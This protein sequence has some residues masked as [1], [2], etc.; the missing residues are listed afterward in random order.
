MH[1]N[2][3]K[4]IDTPECTSEPARLTA[5][6]VSKEERSACTTC[7]LDSAGLDS[8]S[9][10]SITKMWRFFRLF[11]ER[12][13]NNVCFCFFFTLAL[14]K[15]CTNWSHCE[16]LGWSLEGTSRRHCRRDWPKQ[17]KFFFIWRPW[18]VALLLFICDH[19]DY[20]LLDRKCQ[21][22]HNWSYFTII[23]ETNK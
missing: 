3:W 21:L 6:N 1:A 20:W 14:P 22:I 9:F 12:S 13:N 15:I 18:D 17:G 16:M 10:H 11:R 23:T 5:D 4:T 8:I 19:D 7:L 2:V